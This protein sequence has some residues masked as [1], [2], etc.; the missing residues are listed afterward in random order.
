MYL[1]NH[2][3]PRSI[4]L[5][6][7]KY[8]IEN[9]EKTF[10]NKNNI[11]SI[12]ASVNHHRAIDLVERLIQTIKNRLACVKEEKSAEN[13]FHEKHSLKI[14][15]HQLRLYKQKTTKILLLEAH[16]RGETY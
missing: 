2:G 16:F 11:E 4:R 3:I 8:L 10:G 1:E 6:Q 13:L 14:I 15:I 9:Q 5:D 7:A 12:E